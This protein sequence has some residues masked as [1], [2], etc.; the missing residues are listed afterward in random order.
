MAVPAE[1][2]PGALKL[3]QKRRQD[4]EDDPAMLPQ[5]RPDRAEEPRRDG[6][7]HTGHRRGRRR[8]DAA[9]GEEEQPQAERA[10]Q[11]RGDILEPEMHPVPIEIAPQ[12]RAK[13]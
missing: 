12:I 3:D 6:Q 10:D 2:G 9:G 7:Q 11:R 1:G 13:R 5:P 8:A 4:P